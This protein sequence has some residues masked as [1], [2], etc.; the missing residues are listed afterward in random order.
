MISKA[1]LHEAQTKFFTLFIYL[2]YGL[3]FISAL[4]LSQTAPKYLDSMDYYIR[5]YIC[6]FLMWRFNPL[7]EKPEF[8]D[9]DRKIAF[10][11]GLF[12]LTTTALNQYLVQFKDII[13]NSI[14]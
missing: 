11:A 7:R 4:G 6:L 8:T 14:A 2:S 10:S 3:L 9:L 5:I 1:N 12:I 13:K